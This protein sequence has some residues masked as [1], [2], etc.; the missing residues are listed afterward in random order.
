MWQTH[1]QLT[2]IFLRKVNLM[3]ILLIYRLIKMVKMKILILQ[4]KTH[5]AVVVVVRCEFLELIYTAAF[6]LV[7]RLDSS[8]PILIKRLLICH[9]RMA[10]HLRMFLQRAVILVP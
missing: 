5:S 9:S 3:F 2:N 1:D 10:Q 4:P 8:Y 7:V 6:C